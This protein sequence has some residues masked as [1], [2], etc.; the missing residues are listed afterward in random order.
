MLVFT[1]TEELQ[2]YLQAQGNKTIGFVPTMG[3]LHEGHLSLIKQSVKGTDITVCSIFVNP[4][5]FNNTSDFEKYPRTVAD[6]SVMLEK[7]GCH[8]LYAPENPSQVYDGYTTQTFDFKGLDTVMEGEFRPGHFNGMANVVFRLFEIVK[9]HKTYFGEKDYQQLT[10]VRNIVAPHFAH[11]TVVPCAT[12]REKDGLAMSSRNRRLDDFQR[13]TASYI[14]KILFAAS[15]LSEFDADKV[16]AWAVAEFAKVEGI[17][18]EYFEIANATTLLPV[19]L[20]DKN[21]RLFVAAYVGEVRLIDNVANG[22]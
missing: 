11:L 5:Q 20:V 8:V 4:T 12:T 18:L 21:C 15:Q 14:P 19:D 13:K 22:A 10:I 16:V 6:D 9:P 7:A 17:K 2:N 1:K 3:A